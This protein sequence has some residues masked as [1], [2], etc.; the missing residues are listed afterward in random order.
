MKAQESLIVI[1]KVITE[2]KKKC[3]VRRSQDKEFAKYFTME[4]AKPM[5]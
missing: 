2:I 4:Q 5:A 3:T 1:K